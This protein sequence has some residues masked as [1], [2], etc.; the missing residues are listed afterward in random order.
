MEIS[1]Q[2]NLHTHTPLLLLL[3]LTLAVKEAGSPAD[4]MERTTDTLGLIIVIFLAFTARCEWFVSLAVF[5]SFLILS[6]SKR[7][8]IIVIFGERSVLSCTY[9]TLFICVFVYFVGGGKYLHNW[10]QRCA[11]QLATLVRTT[12]CETWL[13][14]G[15][16][17][18]WYLAP[19]SVGTCY[20]CVELH[21]WEHF[22]AYWNVHQTGQQMCFFFES[23][24]SVFLIFEKYF[25]VF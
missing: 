6:F 17:V 22:E 12:G 3:L 10:C 19:T 24:G 2:N 16:L 11:R 9:F 13:S 23:K 4:F 7:S 20:W 21:I 5:L 8:H 1:A 15:L 18:S 14:Q 25:N